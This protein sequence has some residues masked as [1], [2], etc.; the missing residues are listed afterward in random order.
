MTRIVVRRDLHRRGRSRPTG[1]FEGRTRGT[2]GETYHRPPPCRPRVR[3]PR[4]LSGRAFLEWR[5]AAP[6]AILVMG[7]ER[8]LAVPTR[9]TDVVRRLVIALDHARLLEDYIVVF[10]ARDVFVDRPHVGIDCPVDTVLDLRAR[11]TLTTHSRDRR[12]PEVVRVHGFVDTALVG[13]FL[14]LLMDRRLG[15]RAIVVFDADA[16]F[17]GV[18]GRMRRPLGQIVDEPAGDRSGE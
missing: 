17:R 10:F 5:L 14:Q 15:E 2:R 16:V 7:C 12:V 13:G 9:V 1:S 11:V 18:C 6:R 4:P 8:L 3:R